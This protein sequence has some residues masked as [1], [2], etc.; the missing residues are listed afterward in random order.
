LSKFHYGIRWKCKKRVRRGRL[1]VKSLTPEKERG[2][3]S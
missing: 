2:A 1:K 3:Q